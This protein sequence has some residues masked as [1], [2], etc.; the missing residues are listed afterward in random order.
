MT[1]IVTEV[2]A[3]CVAPHLTRDPKDGDFHSEAAMC[4]DTNLNR[5]ATGQAVMA[6]VTT[7]TS[8]RA[9]SSKANAWP[10]KVKFKGKVKG[11]GSTSNTM[12]ATNSSKCTD[13][14]REMGRDR[15]RQWVWVSNI[16][17]RVDISTKVATSTNSHTCVSKHPNSSKGSNPT[18][19]DTHPRAHKWAPTL[20]T[21]SR[22]HRTGPWYP[23]RATLPQQRP[24]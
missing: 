13:R 8:I 5:A 4:A 16:R 19:P 7:A 24:A 20:S 17:A 12:T 2:V 3:L 10:N 6:T 14:D 18:H 1:I 9:S 22:V 15:D 11:K 21:D 23:P